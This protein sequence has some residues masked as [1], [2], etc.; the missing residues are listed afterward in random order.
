M[1]HPNGK[2]SSQSSGIQGLFPPSKMGK[3]RSATCR[4]GR[5]RPKQNANNSLSPMVNARRSMDRSATPRTPAK[6]KDE[7]R[8]IK[9]EWEKI[10]EEKL[11]MDRQRKVEKR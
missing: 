7:A 8:K 6:I 5:S 3:N 1:D 11:A 4:T 10:R 9:I 2:H